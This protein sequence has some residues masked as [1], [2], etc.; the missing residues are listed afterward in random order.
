MWLRS[1]ARFLTVPFH[2][3]PS[4]SGKALKLGTKGK[5]VDQFVD[6]L[7]SEGESIYP[8]P[9][10]GSCDLAKYFAEVMSSTTARVK[11]TT[12]IAPQSTGPGRE[13]WEKTLYLMICLL[14]R[15]LCLVFILTLKR[16][17]N[18]QF[19][20]MVDWK[21]WKLPECCRSVS[22][23]NVPRIWSLRSR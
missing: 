17:S 1:A 15:C 7:K 11:D 14:A 18:C 9:V 5:D 23:M 12:E 3:R 19:A 4:S 6:Q 8:S 21:T 20:E 2:S 16:I 13:R 22:L 10:Q